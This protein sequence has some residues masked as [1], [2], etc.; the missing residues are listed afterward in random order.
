MTSKSLAWHC[1]RHSGLAQKGLRGFRCRGGGWGW[2]SSGRLAGGRL[3]HLQFR[4]MLMP[5]YYPDRMRP[6]KKPD[7]VTIVVTKMACL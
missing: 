5:T 7:L 2:L 4:R 3:W 1:E 6:A